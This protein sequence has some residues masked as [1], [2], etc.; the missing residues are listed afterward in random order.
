MTSY[1]EPYGQILCKESLKL[2]SL[3]YQDRGK[4]TQM[5]ARPAVEAKALASV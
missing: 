2:A 3:Q 4:I 1:E 5:L